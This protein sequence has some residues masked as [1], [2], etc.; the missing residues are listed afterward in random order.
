MPIG[1]L[2]TALQLFLLFFSLHNQFLTVEFEI[3]SFCC[4]KSAPRGELVYSRDKLWSSMRRLVASGAFVRWDVGES[5]L[6]AVVSWFF[7]SAGSRKSYGSLASYLAVFQD[8]SFITSIFWAHNLNIGRTNFDKCYQFFL[9]SLNL[10]FT[11]FQFSSTN[12]LKIKLP[13][14]LPSQPRR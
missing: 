3:K 12:N 2:E 6:V 13:S 10:Q 11:R 4:G 7:G 5:G 14:C 8:E 9:G 1:V